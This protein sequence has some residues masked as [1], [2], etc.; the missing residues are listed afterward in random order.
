MSTTIRPVLRDDVV[1]TVWNDGHLLFNPNTRSTIKVTSADQ[2][3]I[4]TLD[5]KRSLTDLEGSSHNPN[6]L[7]KTLEALCRGQFLLNSE[8]TFEFLFP[9]QQR[10]SW[11]PSKRQW[12]YG[13]LYSRTTTWPVALPSASVYLTLSILVFCGSLGLIWYQSVPL[14]LHPWT[15]NDDWLLG[16]FSAYAGLS[17][18]M[19][20]SAAIQASMLSTQTKHVDI[21]VKQTLGIL[22]LGVNRVPIY[23]TDTHTQRQFAG[24]GIATV[25]LAIGVCWFAESQRLNGVGGSVSTALLL[26]LT[27]ELCP[28][29]DTNGAQLLETV[30]VHKQRLRT[31]DFLR[32]SLLN[33]RFGD[34]EGQQGLRITLCIWLLWFGVAIHLLG[35][36]VLPHLSTLLIQTLQYPT[37][38]GQMWLGYISL[39]ISLCYVYFIFQGLRLSGNLLEQIIPRS[40]K[41]DTVPT[42]ESTYIACKNVFPELH[43]FENIETA[44]TITISAGTRIDEHVDE[45]HIWILLAGQVAFIEPKP[46]GGFST[47][48]ELPAPTPLLC[49]AESKKPPVLWSRSEISLLSLPYHPEQWHTLRDNLVALQHLKPFSELS[50]QWQWVLATQASARTIPADQFV[51]A[52]GDASNTLYLLTHGE[53]SVDT[54]PP[55]SL[56]APAIFGEM[57]ILSEAPRSA[58]VRC[59][60]WCTVVVLP[61][62]IIRVCL[63]QHPSMQA[64]LDDLVSNR[65]SATAVS[66]GGS[67]G[68]Q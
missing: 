19:S 8:E 58:N 55:V 24:V 12:L 46:E 34:V 16:S 6:H 41:I 9:N 68:P 26:L 51:L 27:W 7:L 49:P 10:Q 61:A 23:H 39:L 36:Y 11:T 38:L 5:G 31:Q 40:P 56:S 59:T 57:G 22:H 25:L 66:N 60:T 44:Q 67:N 50:S 18:T 15:I 52:K 32:S 2:S 3:W 13:T 35:Q 30:T 65:L 47:L 17:L 14:A 43:P 1:W 28:F 37:L 4:E 42:S 21:Q 63:Q 54:T 62:H 64:W 45:T 29:F 48:F 33:S 53:V 20:L